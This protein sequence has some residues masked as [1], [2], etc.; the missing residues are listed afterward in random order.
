[1]QIGI[2]DVFLTSVGFTGQFSIAPG[3][4][5]EPD[6]ASH[7]SGLLLIFRAYVFVY[8]SCRRAVGPESTALASMT[9]L[10]TWT[11]SLHMLFESC[12]TGGHPERLPLA[13]CSTNLTKNL[14]GLH[15][16]CRCI[17]VA[18]ERRNPAEACASYSVAC[19]CGMVHR[20]T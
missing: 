3:C 8:D 18:V 7:V 2:Q 6:K 16:L 20:S 5:P 4:G 17:K 11:S 15:T 9:V 14:Y 12:F 10:G 1:M 19:S 13:C